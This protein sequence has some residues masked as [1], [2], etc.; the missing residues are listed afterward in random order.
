MLGT[1][2]YTKESYK[3]V[4]IELTQ[5]TVIEYLIHYA[6]PFTGAG[7]TTVPKGTQIKLR[8]HMSDTCFYSSAMNSD[9]EDKLFELENNKEGRLKDRCTGISLFVSL[10]LLKG[11]SVKYISGDVNSLYGETWELLEN[12]FSVEGDVFNEALCVD[13]RAIFVPGGYSEFRKTAVRYMQKSNKGFVHFINNSLQQIYTV[14]EVQPMVFDALDSLYL[15]G[16]RRIAMNAIKTDVGAGGSEAAMFEAVLEWIYKRRIPKN[17]VSIFLVDKRRGFL[18]CKW[19]T[20]WHNFTKKHGFDY[21]C[22]YDKNVVFAD[23]FC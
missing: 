2:H 10:D 13:G 15:K 8:Q 3:D 7:V 6:A 1:R 4:I 9:I 12:I 14:D 20:A 22:I 17:T 18:T 23:I 11:S 19:S 16:A 21:V 5:D